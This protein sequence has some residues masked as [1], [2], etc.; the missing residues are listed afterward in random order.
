MK[1]R[2][3]LAHHYYG[4]NPGRMDQIPPRYAEYAEGRAARPDSYF[5]EAF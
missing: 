2:V 5:R 4:Y 1:K 3:R